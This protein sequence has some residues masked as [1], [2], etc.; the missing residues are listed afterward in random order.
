MEELL[1]RVYSSKGLTRVLKIA[2]V[3]CVVITLPAFVLLLIKSIMLSPTSVARLL[4]ITGV[5]FVAVS[6]LRR[7]LDLPRPYE[8]YTFYDTP[9]K[10]RQGRSFPSRHVFSIS[11]IGTVA[12]GAYPAVGAVLLILTLIL[13]I[14]RVLLGI[15]FLRDVI[16]GGLIGIFSGVIGLFVASPFV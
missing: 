16:A 8:I 1:K 4:L 6:L 5:P 15:H 2:S 9:P 7:L 13:A 12:V 3:A 14:S 11:L 10:E